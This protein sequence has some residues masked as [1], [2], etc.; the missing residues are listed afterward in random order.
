[1]TEEQDDFMSLPGQKIRQFSAE[2][3]GGIEFQ[4]QDSSFGVSVY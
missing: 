3:A 2:L 1:M 4:V